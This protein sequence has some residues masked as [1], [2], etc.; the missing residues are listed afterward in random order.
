[1]SAPAAAAVRGASHCSPAAEDRASPQ[2]VRVVGALVRDA[3]VTRPGAET[4][5]LTVDMAQLFARRPDV[6]VEVLGEIE[7]ARSLIR[8]A[9]RR[10]VP[11]VTANKALVARHGE[12]L[13]DLAART[14]TPFRYEAS[15]LAGVPF[16]GTFATRPFAS[17][18]SAITGIVNGT[19]NFVLS[20]MRET[21]A[22]LAD[23][24]LDA[25]RRGFAEPDPSQDINGIDAAHKLAILAWH[26]GFGSAVPD[27]IET[28]GI[29]AI[30][31]ADVL[32]ADQFG[33][34]IKPIARIERSSEGTTAFVGPAF[35]PRTNRLASIDGVEN[36]LV[37]DT[38]S[39]RLFFSGPGAG[40]VPTATTI[41][42]D[43]IEAA[44][45][46]QP[47]PLFRRGRL[48]LEAPATPW[49]I[50]LTAG[51]LPPGD[52]IAGFLGSYG[53]WGHRSLTQGHGTWLVT[54]ACSRE[55]VEA[56][57]RALMAAAPC[58]AYA[59]RALEG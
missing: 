33:G 6:I 57:L 59:S 5:P 31:A 44:R 18:V 7:S 12:E 58:D 39:G 35:V 21:G 49:L 24:T 19:T 42:D 11:V 40:P 50:R 16:L 22:Q 20:R 34:A 8:E 38:D 14:A 43:V 41:L 48:S 36:A 37:L 46:G 53:I 52:E 23:A 10:R 9:L 4:I 2:P 45:G 13:L 30:D 3:T 25:Q 1:M 54:Y 28:I 32:A 56:A 17:R 29:G 47:H 26:F 15:V 51:R 55:R 27:A